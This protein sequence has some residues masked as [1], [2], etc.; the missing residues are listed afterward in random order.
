MELPKLMIEGN[1]CGTANRKCK[2]AFMTKS[3]TDDKLKI[4]PRVKNTRRQKKKNLLT[5]QHIAEYTVTC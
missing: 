1:R 5:N 3:F 4:K 2:H